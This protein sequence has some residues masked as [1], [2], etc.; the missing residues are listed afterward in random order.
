MLLHSELINLIAHTTLLLKMTDKIAPIEKALSVIK[1]FEGCKLEAYPDP[2]TGK[3]PWTIGW[4]S[5]T[6][7]DG[8]KVKKGDVISAMK[9]NDLLV[10]KV[11]GIYNVLVKSIPC[12]TKLNVN[13]Q[14]ALI[15]FTYNCG[16]NWYNGPGFNTLTRVIREEKFN[17]VPD[18]LRLYINPGGPSESGLRRRRSSEIDLWYAIPEP[19]TKEELFALKDQALQIV[20][21]IQNSR[22]KGDLSEQLNKLDTVKQALYFIK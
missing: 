2:E 15:S 7:Q 1:Q 13:Q 3:E 18:A 10:L 16:D 22:F 5:T 8:S 11:G 12:W 9:A 6:Y 4:G 14:A 20:C 21:A 19:K 17:Q